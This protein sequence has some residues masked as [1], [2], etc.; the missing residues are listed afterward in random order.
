MAEEQISIVLKANIDNYNKNMSIAAGVLKDLQKQSAAFMK[1]NNGVE[2]SFTKIDFA[3]KKFG[4][5]AGVLE[6]KLVVVKKAMTDLV[7]AG[8]ENTKAFKDLDTQYKIITNRIE[9]KAMAEAQAYAQM[10]MTNMSLPRTAKALEQAGQS[11]KKSNMQWTNFALV[12][13]DLP[14]GFRGIQNNLPALLGGIAGV[15]GPLYLAGS[16][17]IA[18]FTAVDNGMIKIGNSVKL[19]T[20]YSEEAASLYASEIVRLNGLYKAA[21]N[22]N[23]SMNERILA[24]KT[25]KDLYP[26]L[27]SQYS[28]E[29][30]TLGKAD[31]A[32]KKLTTTLWAYAKAKAA[33]TA[34][35]EIATKQ[36]DLIIKRAD[37]LDEFS[38]NNIN[39]Y[40]KEADYTADGIRLMSRY[41]L[42][43][44][45]RTRLLRENASAYNNLE[46]AAAKYLKIQE[47]NINAEVKIQEFKEDPAKA[48][49]KAA[50][51]AKK[52]LEDAK[53]EADKLALYIKKR[54]S[55]SGGETTY[56]GEPAAD[57]SNVAK[58][59]KD[60]MDYEKKASKDRVAFLKEQYQLEVSEAEGSFDKI[61]LAEENMRMALDK[62]FMDGSIKLTEYIDAIIELRKKSNQT[63]L[64]ESKAAMAEMLKMGVGI[65]NALGPALD[66]LLEKG[67]SIGE[68][69]SK[70]FEDVIKKLIKVAIAAAIAVA[71]LSLIFPGTVAKAGGAMK[72]FGNLVGGGMG[73]G[74]QLFANGGIV[75][76][77]TMGLMGEYPGAQNN[78]EVVAPLD[79][80]K[81]MIGGGSGSGEFVLRGNDL[82]L[83]IQRS[84]SSLK[85]R[86]G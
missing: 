17:V 85:L 73:L 54:L 22:V 83:A 6:K 48:T 3:A 20:K 47:A 75:S 18:F 41:D 77:P 84:N 74:S 67:A 72:M 59:F 5:T 16:A 64:A 61:K 35:E 25:L 39:N 55:A 86:R 19:T 78:P 21:T 43:L 80:L 68:V 52:K 65:M 2:D 31:A 44:D 70:A 8:Q 57:P 69:L 60:K 38:K 26:G 71:L 1:I 62:G 46:A 7:V 51:A 15:A 13:Q 45:K 37:L 27:L 63:V 11:V 34:L 23:I 82:I 36:N 12:L 4:E 53:K 9:N 40:S 76:G 49:E 14:Y 79:K 33:Q 81:D 28:Q 58:L 10:N 29:E 30:I 32:F 66:M 42:E 24:A 56:V 50:K